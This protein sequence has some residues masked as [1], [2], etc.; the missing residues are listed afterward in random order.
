MQK[1]EQNPKVP[2]NTIV[3]SNKD[4]QRR[5]E[6]RKERGRKEIC[7][8]NG[9]ELPKF[10]EEHSPTHPKGSMNLKKDKLGDPHLGTS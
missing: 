9:H 7:R 5:E 10:D 1:N 8:N 4:S 6:E 3:S 2:W